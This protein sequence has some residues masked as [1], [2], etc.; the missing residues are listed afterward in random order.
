MRSRSSCLPASTPADMSYAASIAGRN[1][2]TTEN[3][4]PQTSFDDQWQRMVRISKA[5]PSIFTDPYAASIWS[6]AQMD[7]NRA[8][9][10]LARIAQIDNRKPSDWDVIVSGLKAA[11]EEPQNKE[12]QEWGQDFWV[13][14]FM[15]AGKSDLQG[16]FRTAET[17]LDT[18]LAELSRTVRSPAIGSGIGITH[19]PSWQGAHNSDLLILRNDT[20][21]NLSLPAIFVTIEGA[22]GSRVTH[23]HHASMWTNGQQC[24]FRYPFYDSDYAS[25]QTVRHP[26]RVEVSVFSSDGSYQDVKVWTDDAYA[27]TIQTY[28]RDLKISPVFLGE[29]VESGTNATYYP[30]AKFSFSGLNRLPVKSITVRFTRRGQTAEA[31]WD[32][33]KYLPENEDVVLRAQSLARF[34]KY[35]PP[36][37]KQ[38]IIEFT[39]TSVPAVITW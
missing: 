25:G 3:T 2:Y 14:L 19:L 27:N 34:G 30:G 7:A 9:A 39:D 38:I 23:L 21:R 18:K 10:I 6:E 12:R 22:D 28:I 37:Q 26:A 24:Y 15:E 8:L 35:G 4:S 13:R 17:A 33:N 32:W 11:T 5:D 31:R 16:Q 1:L 29:Y 36:E 20:G